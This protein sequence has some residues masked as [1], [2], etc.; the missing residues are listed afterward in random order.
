MIYHLEIEAKNCKVT[1][2]LNGF[3]VYRLNATYPAICSMPIN[4]ALIDGI[5]EL[6]I[7]AIPVDLQPAAKD[8]PLFLLKGS[9]KCYPQDGVV[10]PENGTVIRTFDLSGQ[11]AA[12][13]SFE[14]N[15]F[16]FSYLLEKGKRIESDDIVRPYIAHLE[17]LMNSNNATGLTEEFSPR[18]RDYELAF[19]LEHNSLTTKFQSHITENFFPAYPSQPFHEDL[20]LYTQWCDGR[21]WEVTRIKEGITD[22]FQTLDDEEGYNYSMAVFIGYVDGALKV[23]R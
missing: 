21:I 22:F 1:A 15:A 5:N 9:V 11:L 2:L 8:V 3:P 20:L 13:V 18:L 4:I 6:L 14:S 19:G 17:T 16:D 12:S 10:G 7:S 23:V